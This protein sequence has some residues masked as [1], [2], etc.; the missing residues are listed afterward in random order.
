MEV[1]T[2]MKGWS[3]GSR[4]GPSG[5]ES[6]SKSSASRMTCTPVGPV[7]PVGGFSYRRGVLLLRDGGLGRSWCKNGV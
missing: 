3:S 1:E 7:G 6:V 2:V 4:R 5:G